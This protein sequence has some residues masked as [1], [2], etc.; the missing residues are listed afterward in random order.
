MPA[1]ESELKRRWTG[2]LSGRIPALR[3][4]S[5]ARLGPVAPVALASMR[6]RLGFLPEVLPE[7]AADIVDLVD[8]AGIVA[9]DEA[10][11]S[12]MGLDQLTFAGWHGSLL[13]Q[14]TIDR[15]T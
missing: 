14:T 8:P 13:T 1:C 3:L 6:D 12:S 10:L 9:A 5:I 15:R 11:V 4:G 2:S 7:R